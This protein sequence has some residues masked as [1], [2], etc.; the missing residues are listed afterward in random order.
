MS[1]L[2]RIQIFV[3]IAILLLGCQ[4]VSDNAVNEDQSRQFTNIAN[5]T[6]HGQQD[7]EFVINYVKQHA[8][9]TSVKAANGKKDIIV[10]IRVPHAKRFDLVGI[11]KDLKN[12]IKNQLHD[13]KNVVISTDEKI[14]LEVSDLQDKM[15]NNELTKKQIEKEVKRI[16][17]LSKEQT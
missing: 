11:R 3:V 12:K 4:S 15:N 1:Y 13:D 2:F 9:V 16:I 17:A 6:K 7:T 8:D 5:P 14:Y 10:A